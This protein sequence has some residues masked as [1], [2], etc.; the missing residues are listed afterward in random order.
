MNTIYEVI[1][2]FKSKINLTEEMKKEIFLQKYIKIIQ[3]CERMVLTMVE[4]D[5]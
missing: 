1:H 5:V 4:N 3:D 2:S